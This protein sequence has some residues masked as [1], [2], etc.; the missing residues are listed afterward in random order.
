MNGAGRRPLPW[1]PLLL[2]VFALLDLRVELQLLIDHFT[3]SSLAQIPL[4]HPL[5]VAVLLLLP[6]LVRST[7]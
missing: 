4:H 7:R 2:G 3:W 6:A 1:V 5:A